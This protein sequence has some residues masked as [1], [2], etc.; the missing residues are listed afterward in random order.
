[1]CDGNNGPSLPALAGKD[2][3][4]IDTPYMEAPW[5]EGFD[6]QKGGVWDRD[7]DARSKRGGGN[8]SG[9]E[10][11]SRTLCRGEAKSDLH[12][13]LLRF[14]DYVGLTHEEVMM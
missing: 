6:H 13:E 2:G 14:A 4:S 11:P 12:F 8:V 7:T 3:V 9:I 1:M 10:R 5:M